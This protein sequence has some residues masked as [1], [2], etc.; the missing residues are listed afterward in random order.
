ME[1][2]KKYKN[3]NGILD[4]GAIYQKKILKRSKSYKYTF[5]GSKLSNEKIYY[6]YIWTQDCYQALFQ[7]IIGN[8]IIGSHIFT[9]R[10][11]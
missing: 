5:K 9:Q 1:F 7:R 4:F 3:D 2:I 11:C 6:K 10:R 8:D